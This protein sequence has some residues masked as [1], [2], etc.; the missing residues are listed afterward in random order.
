L[1]GV[2]TGRASGLF[3]HD[4]DPAGQSWFYEGVKQGW[5]PVTRVHRTRRGGYHVI[6]RHPVRPKL[7][8]SAGRLMAG[9]DTRGSGGY[10]IWPPSPGYS[11]IDNSEPA[12]LPRWIINRPTRP[13][14]G[15]PPRP[16]PPT[17]GGRGGG[18]ADDGLIRFVRESREGE[19]NNR[20]FWAA[21][22]AAEAGDRS[23]GRA[24]IAAACDCGLSEMEAQRTVASASLHIG[25]EHA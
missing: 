3:V 8:N 2:P 22:R 20:L 17:R 12:P 23:L 10:V 4:V 14:Q 5:F 9:V 16:Y 6:F 18:E 15:P 7:G 21:C 11:L 1:I 25:G 19:R 13:Q 24:L